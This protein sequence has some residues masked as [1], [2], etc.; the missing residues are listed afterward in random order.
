RQILTESSYALEAWKEKLSAAVGANGRLLVDLIPELEVILGPQP[1]E[2][3]LGPNEA[4]NR[5]GLVV[6]RFLRAFAAQEHPLVIFLDDLQWADPASL[7][8]LGSILGDRQTKHLLFVGAYRDNE[9]D[10]AHP[11][12]MMLSD[13]QKAGTSIHEI[14][15]DPLSPPTV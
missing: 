8:L 6:H 9:V 15:L 3:T 2:V 1:A 14:A 13:L 4:I 11:L 7:R 12:R 5:F 10:A